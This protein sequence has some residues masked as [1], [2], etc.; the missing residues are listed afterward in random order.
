MGLR[1]FI[2]SLSLYRVNRAAVG[3]VRMMSRAFGFFLLSH[4]TNRLLSYPMNRS[5][6]GGVRMMSRG[7][8]VSVAALLLLP[9]TGVSQ[10]S[11]TSTEGESPSVE[12]RVANAESRLAR[13]ERLGIAGFVQAR[14]TH[15]DDATPLTN[16]YVRRARL[17]LRYAG[18]RSRLA[19]SLEGGQGTVS[20]QDAYFDLNITPNRGQQQG[21]VI[22]AGQFLRPF[23]FEVERSE[24]EREFPERPAGW[25][26]FFPGNR[27]Q[28]VDVSMGLTPTT[29]AN[30]A[31]VNGNGAST[32]AALSLRE[33]DDHK[34]VMVRLRQTLFQ[35]RIDLAV[36][37]YVGRQTIPGTAAQAAVTGYVDENGNGTQDPTEGTIVISPARAGRSAIEGDRNRWGAAL[38]AFDVVGGTLRTEYVGAKSFTT[39]LGPGLSHAV[40]TAHAWYAQ[41]L[42]YIAAGFTL[43]A[44]FDAY[45]PDLDDE[46]RIRDD[47]AQTT[48]GLV[49]LRWVGENVRLS[50]AW[51]QPRI[52][53]YSKA[54]DSVRHV[55]NPV[56]TLQGLYRF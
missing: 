29:I 12:E 28:G 20:I 52:T 22:R 4:L 42:R 33:P 49:A 2:P 7:F 34:D 26:A 36:S 21:A 5:A 13:L 35:P 19:V 50:L 43:G 18:D 54:N 23:G 10:S 47:G 40:A 8:I 55:E 37:Y 17:N 27:D 11:S 16:L 3:G 6:V 51:E 53:V 14:G 48:I 38:T 31:V 1:A 32:A 15:Q 41:Y 45:D 25:A 44:R 24:A 56:W 30:A 39:N 9:T 46:L